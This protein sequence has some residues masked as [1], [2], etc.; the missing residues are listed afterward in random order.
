MTGGARKHDGCPTCSCT[1]GGVVPWRPIVLVLFALALWDLVGFAVGDTFFT[2]PAY[3]ELRAVADSVT[4]GGYQ[5]GMRLYAVAFG[6]IVA[7]LT[8]ALL[9][10]RRTKGRTNRLLAVT[11][12]ALAGWWAAWCAGI[13]AAFIVDGVVYAWGNIGTRLALSA[14]A[15]IVARTPPPPAPPRWTPDR[16]R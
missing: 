2:S 13:V 11:L 9:T 12:S 8:Y 15:I 14:I 16:A 4:I 6:C 10:Y 7:P 1:T 5:L 3:G